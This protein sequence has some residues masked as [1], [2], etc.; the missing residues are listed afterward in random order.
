MYFCLLFAFKSL[1]QKPSVLLFVLF[2]GSTALLLLPVL[3]IPLCGALKISVH[4]FVFVYSLCAMEFSFFSLSLLFSLSDS[5]QGGVQNT[6][7]ADL[8]RSSLSF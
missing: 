2:D 6:D 4:I 1:T 5:I 7:C 8:P 3:R